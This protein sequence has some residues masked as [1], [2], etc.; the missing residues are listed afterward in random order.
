MSLSLKSPDFKLL[1]HL[2]S[3]FIAWV[4]DG[5]VLLRKDTLLG[6][7][8]CCAINKQGSFIFHTLLVTS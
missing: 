6:E 7:P 2:S 5:R 3:E 1:L 8:H 4:A